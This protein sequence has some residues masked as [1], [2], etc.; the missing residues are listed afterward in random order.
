MEDPCS[1]DDPG[2][3]AF[4]SSADLLE[5]ANF[6]TYIGWTPDLDAIQLHP[7]L[8]EKGRTKVGIYGLGN[9]RDERLHRSFQANKVAFEPPELGSHDDYFNIMMI[10]QN[11]YK[12]QFGGAPNKNCIH[13]Q[14]LPKFFDLVLDMS[15]TA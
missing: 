14:M 9:V 15:M 3:E 7:V 13:E 5:A 6:M 11:R 10:H 1:I 12:G 8:I 2:E 4:L